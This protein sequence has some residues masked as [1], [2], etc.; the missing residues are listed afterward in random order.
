MPPV[1]YLVTTYHLRQCEATTLE[2]L[3][4]M[5]RSVVKQVC[6]STIHLILVGDNVP[7]KFAQ[8]VEDVIA[9]MGFNVLVQ[10][11]HAHYKGNEKRPGA[12]NYA[13]QIAK[14]HNDKNAGIAFVG[15]LDS[16]DYLSSDTSVNTLVEQLTQN[17]ADMAYS[18][19]V[20]INGDRSIVTG[21]LSPDV[22]LSVKRYEGLAPFH[23]CLWPLR[24]FERV[25]GCDSD[26]QYA[27]D[28]NLMLKLLECNPKMVMVP[29]PLY[30]YRTHHD[31]M[32]GNHQSQI[33]CAIEAAQRSIARQKLNLGIRIQWQVIEGSS[34]ATNSSSDPGLN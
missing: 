12:I 16:D 1:V 22:Y 26:L 9:G 13:M 14:Q 29:M 19:R 7:D 4:Q 24:W 3:L 30:T 28:Y 10:V 33:A 27:V 20:I 32:S 23:L 15:L 18:S 34:L 31:Q 21:A 8:D 5:L 17:N 11:H 25:G 6:K 2:H